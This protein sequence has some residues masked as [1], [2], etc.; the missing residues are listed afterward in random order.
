MYRNGVLY[1]KTLFGLFWSVIKDIFNTTMLNCG[2][3]LIHGVPVIMIDNE[4][5]R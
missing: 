4:I 1:N 3:G 2:N 5:K